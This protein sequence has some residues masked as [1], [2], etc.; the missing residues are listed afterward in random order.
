LLNL[1]NSWDALWPRS[2]FHRLVLLPV[3]ILARVPLRKFNRRGCRAG[4]DP[5]SE[6]EFR[7]G[8]A[9]RHEAMEGL[10]VPRQV[11]AFV[12]RRDTASTS[13]EA[14][15]TCPWRRSSWRKLRAYISAWDVVTALGYP[16]ADQ[17][18]RSRSIA[19]RYRD[20]ARDGGSFGLPAEPVFIL[21]G[22]DPLMDMAR[23]AINVLGNCLA[24]VVVARWEGDFEDG[25]PAV[26]LSP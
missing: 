24:T 14:P 26:P 6:L 1:A 11:V 18:R 3:A 22:I 20:S 12:S 21:L 7:G 4:F 2:R 9:A 19:C 17:Q 16:Y 13:T 25:E 15:C 23:T 5:R 10:G 8:F